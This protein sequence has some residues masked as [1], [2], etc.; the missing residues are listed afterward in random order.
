MSAKQSVYV[1]EIGATVAVSADASAVPLA[2][3]IRFGGRSGNLE[4]FGLV[5]AGVYFLSLS[6]KASVPGY[7]TFSDSDDDTSLGLHFGA[8]LSAAVSPQVSLGIEAKYLKAEA[9]FYGMTGNVDSAI[10]LLR[11]A[12]DILLEVRGA[13]H[14][15]VM[16]I[17]VNLA[18][19]LRD[20]GAPAEAEPLLRAAVT[21]FDTR[22]GS[23]Q[24]PLTSALVGLGQALTATGRPA[25]AR[26]LLERALAL[27]I[28]Q[29]G[30]SNWRVGE[31]QV[32][33]AEGLAAL[34]NL[35]EA[36]RL[37]RQGTALLTPVA[38]AQPH[39]LR[40]ARR[41]AAR[42]AAGRRADTSR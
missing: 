3:S 19:A 37:V 40:E 12:R 5:G 35:A 17:E 10:T 14:R 30:A 1:P 2:A 13:G 32:A 33:L 24:A 20:R 34:G 8:G 18:R 15:D 41:V 38:S 11:A 4:F 9:T 6:E 25:E 28:A 27:G 21:R 42:L 26:P 36:E 22:E 23:D 29:N 31:F 7:G 39:L 16:I